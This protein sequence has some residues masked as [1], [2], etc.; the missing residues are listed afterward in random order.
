VVV[1]VLDLR[2]SH[3]GLSVNDAG[4]IRHVWVSKIKCRDRGYPNS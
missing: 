1:V 3:C 2:R 4:R